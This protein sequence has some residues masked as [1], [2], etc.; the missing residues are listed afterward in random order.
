MKLGKFTIILA[1]FLSLTAYAGPA[2]MGSIYLSQPGGS[3]FYARYAGDEW[4]KVKMTEDG[5][6]IAQERDGWWY[7][8]VYDG[9]GRK[10]ATPHKVGSDVPQDVLQASRQIPFDRLVAQASFM[11]HPVRR[12]EMSER[13]LLGKLGSKS[14]VGEPAVKY[15]LVIL[16]EYK[17]LNEKFTQSR[18]EFVNMLMQEGYSVNG[19]TGS[20]KDYFEDQ[21]GGRFEFQLM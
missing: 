15:G 3:G 17:G 7:Y 8:A 13:A 6:A 2:R 9:S 20:A 21:F 12:K 19:A 11:R 14:V 4:M 1:I 18:E 10:S 16:A 5:C